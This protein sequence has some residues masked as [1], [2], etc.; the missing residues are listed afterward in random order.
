LARLVV[1]LGEAT[2]RVELSVFRGEIAR[3]L[4][5][6]IGLAISDVRSASVLQDLVELSTRF[7]VRLPRAFVILSKASVSLEGVVRRLHPAFDPTATLTAR[8]EAL[9]LERL[10]PRELKG[11]GLRTALQVAL[12]VQELPLQLGQTLMDLERGQLQVVI[13]SDELQGIGK[14]LRGVGMT[15]FGGVIAGALIVSGFFVLVQGGLSQASSALLAALAF[16]FAGVTFGV[17]FGWYLTGGKLP[18]IALRGWLSQRLRGQNTG[19]KN[20]NAPAAPALKSP[21]G[22]P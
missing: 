18:K 2:D 11:G 4:D 12:L 14:T 1:R 16:G 10:D 9:L 17:A 13:R 15:I 3:L 7:G 20:L 19:G 6:Y 5:R 21:R 8:A 22:T